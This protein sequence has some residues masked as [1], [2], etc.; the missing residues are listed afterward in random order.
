MCIEDEVKIEDLIKF[1]YVEKQTNEPCA[2][3]CPFFPASTPRL[4]ELREN[5][6]KESSHSKTSC[7]VL[8]FLSNKRIAITDVAI[9]VDKATK[10]E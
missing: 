8:P 7:A 2:V 1:L 3:C 9:P 10:T 6:H 4:N 5:Q